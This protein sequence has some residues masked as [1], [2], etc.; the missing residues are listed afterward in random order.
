MI[1]TLITLVIYLVI[2]GLIWWAAQAIIAVLP[3]PEPIR[4]V[5]NVV[6]VVIVALICIYALLAVIPHGPIRLPR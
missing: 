5:I 3:I 4:T 2:A 1:E 6:I